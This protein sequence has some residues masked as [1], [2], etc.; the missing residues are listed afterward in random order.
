M[1]AGSDE[2][3]IRVVNKYFLPILSKE[4]PTAFVDL[5]Q[6]MANDIFAKKE[7]S[8]LQIFM[9]CL[10]IARRSKL[11]PDDRSSHAS[12]LIE[13]IQAF[14]DLGLP[15][16]FFPFLLTNASPTI[17]LS[18]FD[19]LTFHAQQKTPI[20]QGC[21]RLIQAV[22]PSLFAEQ[23]GEFRIEILRST[24]VLLMR[25]RASTHST[26]K[27]LE[28]RAS[29]LGNIAQELNE[30]LTSAGLF[31][32][33]LV[34]FCKE[35]I[36]PGRSYYTASMGLRTLYLIG[37]E[38]LFTDL[39]VE[40]KSGV[41]SGVRVELFSH[42]ML[43]LLVDRLADPYDEVSRLAYGLLERIKDPEMMP[44]NYLFSKGR[45]LCSSGR[46]D[47]SEGGAKV[48]CLCQQFGEANGYKNVWEELWGS[49]VYDIETGNL[50]SV[51]EE[52]PL[53][54]RLIAL[55]YVY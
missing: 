51:A 52:S 36:T 48:L 5:L 12:T 30:I 31:I 7:T 8:E 18:A 44:L 17:R 43:R 29:K 1:I 54:G 24:R 53:H 4:C 23:D 11:L 27:E 6:N 37:E 3:H 10:N 34:H 9:L 26:V 50:R 33:W 38:G 15:E 28:K 49:L 13:A 20:S 42:S 14:T 55:R 32:G 21:Y 25:L 39:K 22:L 16:T 35:C 47:K 40:V 19:I 2:G 46:A 45:E 41:S